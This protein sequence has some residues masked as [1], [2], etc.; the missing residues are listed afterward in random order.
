[1]MRETSLDEHAVDIS[2]KSLGSI[3]ISNH[4]QSSLQRDIGNGGTIPK[5]PAEGRDEEEKKQEEEPKLAPKRTE[6]SKKNS[7][8]SPNTNKSN[9][10]NDNN[11]TPNNREMPNAPRQDYLRHMANS[12][13]K[14]TGGSWWER[15][16]VQ[17][18]SYVVEDLVENY[19]AD[20][21]FLQSDPLPVACLDR[22]EV[23]AGELLG[24]GTYSNVY[25]VRNLDLLPDFLT[26]HEDQDKLRR[27]LLPD[28]KPPE[29]DSTSNNNNAKSSTPPSPTSTGYAIKHLKAELLQNSKL[30]EAAAADLIMEAKFLSRLDHPN[31]L[32]LR[33]MALG[34]SSTFSTTG[35][36]D[37]YFLLVDELQETLIQRIHR[38]KVE[39][40]TDQYQPSM[41]L[42]KLKLAV[43]VASALAYLHERRI[44][45]R[46]LKPHNIGLKKDGT[47]QLFDFGFCRELPS[48]DSC[49]SGSRVNQQKGDSG[50]LP[51]ETPPTADEQAD[52]DKLYC[53]SG[54]GTLL[55]MSSEVL[56][57]RCYNAK[58]DVYSW[59]MVSYEL[60]TLQKPFSVGSIE[61]HRKAVC[62]R[63]QRPP[64]HHLRWLSTGVKEILQHSWDVNVLKRWHMRDAKN[65]LDGIISE[66]ESARPTFG[67]GSSFGRSNNS[68]SVFCQGMDVDSIIMDISNTVQTRYE[69]IANKLFCQGSTKDVSS[70]KDKATEP[71][72][73]GLKAETSA[74]FVHADA[75]V[76]LPTPHP[77]QERKPEAEEK[78][79]VKTD[80]KPASE[81]STDKE[82]AKNVAAGPEPKIEKKDTFLSGF[83][84]PK[85]FWG[86][87]VPDLPP[88]ASEHALMSSMCM[89]SVRMSAA[90]NNRQTRL[91]G[92]SRLIGPSMNDVR[93]NGLKGNRSPPR[94]SITTLRQSADYGSGRVRRARTPMSAS[95]GKRNSM[96]AL[97]KTSEE[98]E[99]EEGKP[100]GCPSTNQGSTI[101]QTIQ[102]EEDEKSEEVE[103]STEVSL[104][105]GKEESKSDEGGGISIVIEEEESESAKLIEQYHTAC[106]DSPHKTS[107]QYHS[108]CEESPEKKSQDE[109]R[110]S[111]VEQEADKGSDQ[112][113]GKQSQIEQEA[114]N[115]N[116]Q[117]EK[118]LSQ[119]EQET[120]EGGEPPC[121]EEKKKGNPQD[122]QASHSGQFIPATASV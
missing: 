32:R 25:R 68:G 19:T 36:F 100:T 97:G 27:D 67:K 107:Q 16:V 60:L 98:S 57:T 83:A 79:E 40:S 54:K 73:K 20:S 45:F 102:S 56:S 91:T 21:K 61:Q 22:I 85:N 122:D 113:E 84:I 105:E 71:S 88:E 66:L 46:D 17:R 87:A 89:H 33:G 55:Y 108:A 109:D 65:A 15:V 112:D 92:P 24:A 120:D 94:A 48:P 49:V 50:K 70:T 59:A 118:G 26:D 51:A 10:N 44:V 52:E 28:G 9:N 34:G 64:L 11:T 1:M 106:E 121:L 69:Y 78:D 12:G 86:S 63:A 5:D 95:A 81:K 8:G 7:N 6:E 116:D 3:S 72:N 75:S 47:I 30:F 76:S 82:K 31:I 93:P 114:D 41:V 119:K 104:A 43:Q 58:A 77:P 37:S 14:K 29:E 62:D 111:Q 42:Y 80:E 110:Q 90:R 74:T 13:Q 96:P 53:M 23:E 18:S 101:L 38:W 35:L 115:A 4:R 99:E 39:G 103:E 2:E 117:D